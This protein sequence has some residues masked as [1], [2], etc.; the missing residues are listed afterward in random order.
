MSRNAK[1]ISIITAALL[2]L[3]LTIASQVMRPAWSDGR[4]PVISAAGLGEFLEEYRQ[5]SDSYEAKSDLPDGE[6]QY[7]TFNS[8]VVDGLTSA[9]TSVAADGT[10]LSLASSIGPGKDFSLYIDLNNFSLDDQ[11][12][13]L[14]VDVPAGVTAE[15]RIPAN[16]AV[17]SDMRRISENLWSFTASGEARPT[18][19][20]F[21]IV[22]SFFSSH[23]L[24]PDAG[25]IS[26]RLTPSSQTLP[27]S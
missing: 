27:R 25:R 26:L 23:Q 16:A 7:V 5:T 4:V 22:I 1:R 15:V 9:E 17:V 19:L 8:A 24:D 21:D 18:S 14:I 6:V 20:A 11:D 10:S 13:E 2:V 12:V 3:A